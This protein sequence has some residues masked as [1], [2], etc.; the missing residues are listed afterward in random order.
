MRKLFG[1]EVRLEAMRSLEAQLV[2]EFPRTPFLANFG[3]T[4][5]S[6][7]T[8]DKRVCRYLSGESAHN[9]TSGELPLN[10]LRRLSDG[11]S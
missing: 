6:G 9:R 11:R 3:C 4:D 8:D 2:L 5:D 10:R 7:V 1:P